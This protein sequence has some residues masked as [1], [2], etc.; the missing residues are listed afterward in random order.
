MHVFV[1]CWYILHYR[2]L[3]DHLN[4]VFAHIYSLSMSM[5]HLVNCKYQ[6][7]WNAKYLLFAIDFPQASTATTL[8]EMSNDGSN[9]IFLY[10]FSLSFYS[11]NNNRMWHGT[12]FSFSFIFFWILLL[13]CLCARQWHV[14]ASNWKRISFD[15]FLFVR[16]WALFSFLCCHWFND[17][18]N[19]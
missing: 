16:I 14:I 5:S 6:Q 10:F 15:S 13:C 4:L 2:F 19:A 17:A 1:G 3:C 11:H 18:N 12:R 9:R 7:N 8:N